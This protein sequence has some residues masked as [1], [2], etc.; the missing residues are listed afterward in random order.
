MPDATQL[1]LIVPTGVLNR[2]PDKAFTPHPT[3]NA[4]CDAGAS[5]RAY[6]SF[7]P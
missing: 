7:E 2:R 4:R 5:Y 3:N 1:R 6:R